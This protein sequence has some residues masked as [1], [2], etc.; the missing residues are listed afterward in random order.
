MKKKVLI[1]IASYLGL[2]LLCA[3][4]VYVVPSIRGMLVKTY[5][6]EQGEIKLSDEA[7]AYI[8]RKESVYVSTKSAKI[9]RLADENTLVKAFTTAAEIS[10]SDI[11]ETSGRYDGVLKRLGENVVKTENGQAKATGYICY[12]IDGEEAAVTPANMEDLS[13]K[14]LKSAGDANLVSTAKSKCAEGEPLFKLVNNSRWYMVFFVDKKDAAKYIQGNTVRV[15]IGDT[16]FKTKIYSVTLKNG[17]A[18]VILKCGTS[19][20]GFLTDR[21]IDIN[22]TT[23]SASGLLLKKDSIVKKGGKQGVLV[24]NKLGNYIFKEVCIKASDGENCVVYQDLFMDEESNF[25]ETISIY[26]EIVAS[27][28]KEDIKNAE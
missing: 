19:Y 3:V 10:A 1:G 21:K 18:K 14:T 8:V 12:K 9:S 13:E 7:E 23:A 15:G 5:I 6:A 11:D 27:P 28:S 20:D 22:V 25:V 2:I 4:I 16:E 26:D 17:R 24:K